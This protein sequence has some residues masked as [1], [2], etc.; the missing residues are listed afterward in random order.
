[1]EETVRATVA[2]P[3][4]VAGMTVIPEGASV[5]GVVVAAE[6]AGRVKGRASV[7]LRFNE[8]IVAN[9]PYKINTARIARQ[10]EATEGEDAKKIGIG[11]GSARRS[12]RLRAERKV[13]PSARASAVRRAPARS[14]PPAAK[15]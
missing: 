12:V 15:K 11:A 13:R 9:T 3:V 4:V 6:R 7:A 2:T 14:S 8:V 5:T 1:M 10:A